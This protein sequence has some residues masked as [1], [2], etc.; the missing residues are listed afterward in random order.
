MNLDYLANPLNR[1]KKKYKYFVRILEDFL[2]KTSIYV[3][4][5]PLLLPFLIKNYFTNY[6]YYFKD[7]FN[8]NGAVFFVF[9]LKNLKKATFLINISDFDKIISRFGFFF[10][11]KN[12]SIKI[13]N[14]FNKS[15]SFKN[16]NADYYLNYDYFYYFDKELPQTNKNFALPFYLP[17]NYYL[18]KKEKNYKELIKSKKN[19]KIIFSGSTHN[20][21]YGD[22]NF[23]NNKNQKFLNRLEI[24]DI[25]KKNY[26]DNILTIDDPSQLDS[27]YDNKKEILILETNP[28]IS[29]RKKNF[30]EFQ[31]LKLIAES[32]FFLC[33]PGTSMPLCYHL[34]ESC[35]VG[36]IPI[37]SYNNFLYPKLNLDEAL[38]FFTKE[39][40]LEALNN[41]LHM[42]TDNSNIMQ[43]KIIN[44]YNKNLSCDAIS[45]KIINKEC[46]L[47][48]FINLDHAS[49]N[50]R[51][52]RINC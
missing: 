22:L 47:E 13:N 16:K 7:F 19:F 14:K 6:K 34:T 15:I 10:V 12:F 39:E 1:R 43:K 49:S 28:S 3:F 38:F 26:S 48:V 33:M 51:K 50:I 11:L 27:I 18:K 31:H 52:K 42:S 35:L 8:H 9:I 30:S 37:L 25:L 32:N 17:K 24:L 29:K 2:K 23:K 5:L 45:K 46:P 40:L 4:F 20:E 21:W 41:A 44:Y 36:T